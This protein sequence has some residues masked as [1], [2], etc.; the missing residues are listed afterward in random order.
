MRLKVQG[1]LEKHNIS[2][3]IIELEKPA[4]TAR[5]R[6]KQEINPEEICKTILIK[7]KQEFFALLLKGTDLIDFNK[8]K[9]KIGKS[10]I[11]SRDEVFMMVGVEPGAV[12]PILVNVPVLVDCRV[13]EL[14]LLNFSSGNK[15]Y[16]VEINSND[17]IKVLNY[18][19]VDLAKSMQ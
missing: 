5:A 3:R 14:V 12:C 9:S 6:S 8:L 16:G 17:L 18:E 11:A 10:S 2:Y 19:I 4:I 15:L 13:F 1:I 7:H